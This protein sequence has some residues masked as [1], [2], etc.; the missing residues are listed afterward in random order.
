MLAR[1]AEV[2]EITL[3]E[4]SKTAFDTSSSSRS[5]RSSPDIFHAGVV[6]STLS[7]QVIRSHACADYGLPESVECVLYHRGVN[8]TYLLSCRGARFALRLY[9]C[10]WRSQ[11]SID[12][13]LR[14]LRHLHDRGASV[15]MP[16]PRTDGRFITDIPAPEGTRQAV[17]FEWAPGEM[18]RYAD[19]THAHSFGQELAR[20]HHAGDDF[21]ADGTRPCMDMEY[22]FRNPLRKIL[23][24]VGG[25]PS[26]LQRV[27]VLAER[28]E[29]LIRPAEM[30][31]YDWGFCHGDI[32]A[33]N[34]RVQRDQL[35]LFDFDLCGPGWRLSDIASYRLGARLCGVEEPAWKPFIDGY[36]E[37]RPGISGCLKFTGL[38]MILIRL[39]SAA[40]Q[41]GLANEIGMASP[42]DEFLGDMIT[43]CDRIAAE[44]SFDRYQ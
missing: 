20:L 7:A 33:A 35:V 10:K 27:E 21:P 5:T 44:I 24:R 40:H 16:I 25:V 3:I 23:L 42:T 22:L 2:L 4:Q 8:D 43:F 9:R 41:I 1:T 26:I 11:E 15:A 29:E 30:S 13:E 38:F 18:P 6:Y 39:I 31:L 14:A 37:I 36:L 19:F 17:L 28:V 34:A 12:G 32:W